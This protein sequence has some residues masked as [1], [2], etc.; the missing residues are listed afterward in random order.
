[1]ISSIIPVR[2]EENYIESCLDSIINQDYDKQN[3]I[4]IVD[5]C[6]NDKTLDILLK[7]YN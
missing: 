1:M 2:N 3:E 5:G 6:S 4:I 7:K